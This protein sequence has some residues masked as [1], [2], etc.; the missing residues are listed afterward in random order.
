M[1]IGNELTAEAVTNKY[2]AIEEQEEK[3]GG[4]IEVF[5]KHND[6]VEKFVGMYFTDRFGWHW[7]MVFL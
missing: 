5:H 3:P 4:M 2:L 6:K 7:P 1:L